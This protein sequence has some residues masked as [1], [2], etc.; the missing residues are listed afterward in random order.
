MKII[1]EKQSGIIKYVF[2]DNENISIL[3]NQ[4]KLDNKT[5]C[6]LNNKNSE[7][8]EKVILPNNFELGKYLYINGYFVINDEVIL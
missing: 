3:D 5:I 8:I 7:L 1:V 2:E 4:I 6:D